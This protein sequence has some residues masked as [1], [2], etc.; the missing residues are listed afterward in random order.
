MTEQ[1]N[2]G[3]LFLGSCLALIATSVAF[4]VIGDIMGTLKNE[5]VLTN[6]QVG[7]IGGAALWGFTVSMIALGPL[8]DALG[9]K[10]LLWF[11]LI[12]HLAGPLMMIFANG[13]SMLFVGALVLALGNGT[14]EAACNPLV[15]TLFPDNKTVKL[16]QFHVWFPGGIVIGGLICFGLAQMGNHSWQLRLSLIMIPAV[17][18]GILFIGQKFPATERVQSGVSFGGMC[19]ATF[20]RPLF[21]IMFLCMGITASLE[22]GPNRW[23]PA[24]LQSGGMHGILVL[25]WITGLMAVLRNFSGSFVHRLSPPG[26]LCVSAVLGGIGLYWLSFAESIGMAIAAATVFAL[27][28][29][30]FWPTMLGVVAERI[31]KGGALA[32]ALMGGMGMLAS[33]MIA[34]PLIGSAADTYLKDKL[35]QAETTAVLQE[36]ATV[37]PQLQ[38]EA[39]GNLGEDLQP[40]IDAATSVLAMIK[41]DP[42]GAL[43]HPETANALRAA[44]S[45]GV[46]HAVVGQAADILNPADNY[47]GRM[48]FRL[49][50]PYAIILVVVFGAMYIGDKRKGGYKA[51][52]I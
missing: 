49:I 42:E 28:V 19:K 31:P 35:P 33:G 6:T 3:R 32:L 23:I 51:E 50:A 11:A 47:G 44:I 25:V 20:M 46:D 39:K 16:N 9:M 52:E 7:L 22:L 8:C 27:G 30:F 36:V 26:L 2:A 45:S 21:W 34:S 38:S 13:F 5:F 41:A 12:C 48:S 43:P 18:Y 14:V 15:A 4:A 37:F 40:G 17:I 24:I 29:C 1:T 10:R